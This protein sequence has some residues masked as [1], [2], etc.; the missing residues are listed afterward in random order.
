M[1]IN[2]TK[3]INYKYD[4]QLKV[5]CCE[6][7][8]GFSAEGPTPLTLHEIIYFRKRNQ[9]IPAFVYKD[10]IATRKSFDRRDTEDS[11]YDFFVSNERT[12]NILRKANI[13]N[14]REL[15]TIDFENIL[16][17]EGLG[18]TACRQILEAMAKYNLYMNGKNNIIFENDRN[19][20][21]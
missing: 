15:A 9:H 21:A 11:F 7:N 17:I 1:P 4:P 5:S 3:L 14:M 19:T 8:P 6:T 13:R 2:Y 20:K 18:E 16:L 10:K 12:L